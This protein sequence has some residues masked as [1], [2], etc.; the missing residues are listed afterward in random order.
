MLRQSEIM[1]EA[2]QIAFM[3]SE[4]EFDEL[5]LEVE[6]DIDTGTISFSC[7]QTKDGKKVSLSLFDTGR[8]VDLSDLSEELHSE[9][10][11]HTGG[12][13]KKYTVTIDGDGTTRANFEYRP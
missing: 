1:H 9:M 3:A 8:L 12:D 5:V 4:G 11:E 7:Y 2:A 13:L 10:K 6:I